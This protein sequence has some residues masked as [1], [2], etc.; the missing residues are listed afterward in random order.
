MNRG[1]ISRTAITLTALILMLAVAAGCGGGGD[2]V[3]TDP[4][5]DMDQE[6]TETVPAPVVPEETEPVV[7]TPDYAS[8]EPA[9]FGI[10][11]VFFC[12]DCYDLD[13]A[14]LAAL[15]RNAR[16]LRDTGVMILVSGH[17]DDRGSK[18]YNKLLSQQRADAVR[19]YLYQ[20]GIDKNQLVAKGYGMD[21]PLVPNTTARNRA[22]NRRV[23]FVRTEKKK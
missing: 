23:Q 12:F 17:T 13:D 21:K 8:M 4:A 7:E 6:T 14:A 19:K 18:V 1:R 9:D 2:E 15:S 10:E 3:E 20:H 5:A 22:L 11:D 16:I